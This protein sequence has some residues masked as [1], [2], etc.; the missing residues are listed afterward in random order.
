M[1]GA[2]NARFQSSITN[3]PTC[4][5]NKKAGLMTYSNLRGAGSII[6]KKFCS[7]RWGNCL[8][9]SK[10]CPVAGTADGDAYFSKTTPNSGGVGRVSM[11]TSRGRGGF[12]MGLSR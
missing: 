9:K 3:K 7:G 2:R 1:S 11:L 12:V 8:P 10:K 5:G 6:G 4:G